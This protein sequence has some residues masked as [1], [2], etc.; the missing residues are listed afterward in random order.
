[1]PS[2]PA[3]RVRCG[4]LGI[5]CERQAEMLDTTLRPLVDKLNF[6]LNQAVLML[7]NLAAAVLTVLGFWI[8]ARIASNVIARMLRRATAYREINVLLTRVV[9]TAI[10]AAGVFIALGILQLEKTVT[11]L[12]AGAGILTLIIGFAFQDLAANF[13]AGILLQLRHPFRAGHLVRTNDFYGTVEHIDLR[14]T[15]IHTL[16]GQIV[17]LPN[18]DV[19][20]KPLENFSAAGAR[21]VDLP[22][23]VTSDRDPDDVERLAVSAIEGIGG[24]DASRPVEVFYERFGTGALEFTLRF[25]IPFADKEAD[26]LA[27]R[28]EA[29]K[30]IGR[31]F[32]AA[33]IDAE[34]RSG[35]SSPTA[36]ASPAE[37]PADIMT[38]D[39]AEDPR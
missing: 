8:L 21:R 19:F 18:K 29:V 35:E 30:R 24:R 38:P 13:I 37:E 39:A 27:A 17:H 1:M 5:N 33:G 3:A 9:W 32:A 12:V 2:G 34:S 22:V 15:I 7:P 23:T 4:T 36:V 26:F 20:Q 11:S 6:W 14:N 10:V 16:T 31:A 25:W 28:G